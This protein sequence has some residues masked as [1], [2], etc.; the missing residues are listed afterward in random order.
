MNAHAPLAATT[1]A[2]D[3]LA[4][5]RAEIGMM[6]SAAWAEHGRALNY[7]MWARQAEHEACLPKYRRWMQFAA[8]CRRHAKDYI[9]WANRKRDELLRLEMMMEAANDG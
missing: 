2:H 1:P 6:V 7:T 5:L 9:R 3:R 8:D 4:A